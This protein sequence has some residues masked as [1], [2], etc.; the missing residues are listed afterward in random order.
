MSEPKL[1]CTAAEESSV[2][3]DFIEKGPQ[4]ELGRLLESHVHECPACAQ[5]LDGLRR[6]DALLKH[7][8]GVFHPVET[9]LFEFVANGIDP[10]GIIALHLNEC[11]DCRE[12]ADLLYEMLHVRDRHPDPESGYAGFSAE[13]SR[14]NAQGLGPRFRGLLPQTSLAEVASKLWMAMAIPYFSL[15]YRLGRAPRYH[16][17]PSAV[18]VFQSDGEAG[19]AAPAGNCSLANGTSAGIRESSGYG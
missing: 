11:R 18:D 19:S 4:D 9:E 16:C 13:P 6:I 3:L 14:P 1:T 7:H 2:F 17:R 12:A 10:D 8:R 15:G 5:T